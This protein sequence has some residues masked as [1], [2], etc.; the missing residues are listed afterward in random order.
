MHRK[1][2]ILLAATSMLAI[3]AC[4]EEKPAEIKE[5]EPPKA[6]Y[7]S[8]KDVDDSEPKTVEAQKKSAEDLTEDA[9]TFIK[10]ASTAFR[11]YSLRASKVYW[12]FSTNITEETQKAVQEIDAE[13][14]K[15]AVEWANKAKRFN[16]FNLP[17]KEK[18][19]I[20][21]IKAGLTIPAPQ[22]D[23]AAEELAAINARMSAAYST[24]TIQ[25]DGEQVPLDVLEVRMGEIRD[26]AKLKEMWTKWRTNVIKPPADG[27][28]PG[29]KADYAAMVDIANE[30]ARELGFDH[31]KDLWLSKYDMESDE[32]ADEV[33]RLWTQVKPLY[34]ELHCHVRAKLN[35]HYGDEIVSLDQPIRADLLGNMWAQ[36]WG[37]VYDLVKS[38]GPGLSYDLT[39]QLKQKGYTP[40][41]MVETGE[42]F[43]SSLG[44]EPLPQTFWK[45]SQIVKPDDGR[46]VVC[47]ASAWNLDDEEDIRIKMCTKVNAE[48]FQTV[49]HE[50]GHNYYQRAYKDQPYL[51][52]TGAHDGF[53]EA[54]GDLISLS[55]TP[56]YL[57]QIGLI[58]ENQL[59][60]ESADLD[61]LMAQALDKIAFLPFGYLMDKWRWSVFDG[62]LTPESY[63]EGWW[64]LRT[65]YQGIEPPVTRPEN[66]FDPG[67][68]YHIPNHTPYLRYFLSFVMQFQF[69]KA[70]CETAGWEGPLHR[71]SIY[72]SE[73]VGR[74]LN[75]MLEAGAS[76][77][78]PDTLELFTGTREMDGSA[79]ITYFQPL[80]DYLEEENKD[81]KCG[82]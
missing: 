45:R 70:A 71:C 21:G 6:T 42:V 27:S 28:G 52:R 17:P 74:K 33:E 56:E 47:H 65:R 34:K 1:I 76:Q 62:S 16:D 48:D 24:S 22:K 18:R 58:D 41:K 78:W 51:Y 44:F 23:G 40:I 66:A 37:N 15:L 35:E 75:A 31:V 3:S 19:V 5:V 50:L 57:L 79:I 13:G 39:E 43:F 77:P 30:G 81:R 59:P 20:D 12:E 2:G 10:K 7:D 61:L 82:W 36:T 25:L 53:H 8:R 67:G 29:M 72:G 49:H 14:T 69:H 73:E 60:D 26:P 11:E 46:K 80:M 63:N 9:R 32:M 4:K 38:G 54:I 55:I 68:K 64:E